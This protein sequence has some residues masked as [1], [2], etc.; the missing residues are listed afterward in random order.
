[1][2]LSQTAEALTTQSTIDRIYTQMS[3]QSRLTYDDRAIIVG[4]LVPGEGCA[5][6]SARRRGIRRFS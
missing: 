1:M 3:L 5:L 6:K 4:R 2:F